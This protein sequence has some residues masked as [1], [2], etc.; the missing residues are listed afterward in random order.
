MSN[1]PPEIIVVCGMLWTGSGALGDFLFDH[2]GVGRINNTSFTAETAF[3]KGQYSLG[4]IYKTIRK[5]KPI[6]G[7]DLTNLRHFLMGDPDAFSPEVG[8]KLAFNL[9]RNAHVA[10]RL[11][12]PFRRA[13][14]NLV[15]ALEP[16]ASGPRLESH[17]DIFLRASPHRL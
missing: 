17:R 9:A 4:H 14:E 8:K 13:V 3:T 7:T 5:G 2:E 15:S 12:D 6:D 16:A 11:G 10:R 1:P